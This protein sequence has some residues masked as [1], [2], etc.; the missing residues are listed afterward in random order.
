MKQQFFSL[1]LTWKVNNLILHH[2]KPFFF[3]EHLSHTQKTDVKC[4]NE[5]KLY[6]KVQILVL[7]T[8]QKNYT[9]LAD[10]LLKKI[11]KKDCKNWGGKKSWNQFSFSSVFQLSLNLLNL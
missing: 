5:N 8:I 10:W 3:P 7:L 6:T 11:K 1:A 2:Q 4:Q 9:S